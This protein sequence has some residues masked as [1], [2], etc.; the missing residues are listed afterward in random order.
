MSWLYEWS[1]Q[2][3]AVLAGV[4][5]VV[6]SYHGHV[7]RGYFPPTTTR[8]FLAIER[9]LAR[10]TDCLLTVSDTVRAELL[11]LPAPDEPAQAPPGDVLEEDALHGV[12]RAEAEDLLPLRLGGSPEHGSK[13]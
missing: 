13:L 6:H 3:A 5:V 11:A 1:A 4:P 7:F 2:L 9:G 10:R 8:V 12:P